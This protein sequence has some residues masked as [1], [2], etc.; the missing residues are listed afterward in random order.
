MRLSNVSRPPFEKHTQW[1]EGPPTKILFVRHGET[2]WNVRGVIQGWKGAGLNDLGLRQAR[3]AAK[4]VKGMDMNVSVV[5]SSDLKRARQTA[6]ILGTAIGAK[7]KARKD[8]R[9]RRFGAWEGLTISQ[10]L[11][12]FK[13]GKDARQD[14][15][16]AFDPRGGESMTVFAARMDRFLKAVLKEYAGRTVAAITHGGPIRICSCLATG[17]SPQRYFLLGR[18]G[19]VSLTVLAHQGGVWW[20]ELY[21][22]MAHLEG[23]APKSLPPKRKIKARG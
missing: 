18:P 12:R 23:A 16:L 19:N 20:V 14:P 21:N 9:E 15:F 7:V 5:L 1:A 17:I 6:N 4:R 10:V 22:D 3:L 8:L 11:E 13:L 2:D